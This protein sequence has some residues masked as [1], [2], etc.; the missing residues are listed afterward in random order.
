VVIVDDCST[1]SPPG[2]GAAVK[3]VRN[4]A[5]RGY[6]A[7]VNAGVSVSTGDI[8]VLLDSDARPLGDV[9][10]PCLQAFGADPKLGALGF[11]TIDEGGV[12]TGSSI[13]EPD[14]LGLLLGQRLDQA[15]HQL[16]LRSGHARPLFFSCAIAFR[17][18]AFD[19]VQGFDEHFDFLDADLDFSARLYEGGWVQRLE[20]RLVAVHEGG[21]SPQAT[22]KRVVRFH[23]NRWR[24][25][26]KHGRLP[27]RVLFK[28]ALAARHLAEFVTL[29]VL[30]PLLLSR[31]VL[32]DKL[33]CR[34]ELL[35]SVWSGYGNE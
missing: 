10:A 20:P 30:G 28:T 23:R 2:F 11:R 29:Q 12:E 31:E 6:V 5:N 18:A 22:A 3:I 26:E 25:L 16:R 1:D 27:P 32:A 21:G 7:S 8:I 17:R 15:R 14:V 35:S 13:P 19:A 33:L 24:F 9:V 34:R 4:V